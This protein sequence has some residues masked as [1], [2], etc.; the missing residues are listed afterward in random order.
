[1]FF[2]GFS[3]VLCTK[4][5]GHVVLFANSLYSL[6]AEYNSN[7]LKLVMSKEKADPF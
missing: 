5:T 4:K 6:C 2:L 7:Q 1:M 3:R